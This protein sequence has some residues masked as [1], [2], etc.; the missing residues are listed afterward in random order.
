MGDKN[1]SAVDPESPN[2]TKSSWIANHREF[3]VIITT[4]IAT[5]AI[6]LPLSFLF[7]T[8]SRR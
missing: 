6:T 5:F 4:I 2:A 1:E 3:F 7:F 8:E